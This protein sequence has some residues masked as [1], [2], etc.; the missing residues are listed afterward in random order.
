MKN[1]PDEL[2][3]KNIIQIKATLKKNDA[4]PLYIKQQTLQFSNTK[5]FSKY[6]NATLY[7][8]KDATPL[9]CYKVK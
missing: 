4:T 8:R 1:Y 7:Q 5:C 2:S 6:F 3:N 9:Y